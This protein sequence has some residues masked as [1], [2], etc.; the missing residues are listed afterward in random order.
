MRQTSR[1]TKN[2]KK[3]L[4]GGGGGGDGVNGGKEGIEKRGR[5]KCGFLEKINGYITSL[6]LRCAANN[7]N[8]LKL[9]KRHA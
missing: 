9:E 4:C 2:N 1:R 5:K 7:Q 6:E 8:L 3:K